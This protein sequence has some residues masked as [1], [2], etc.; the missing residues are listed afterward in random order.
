[1]DY[2]EVVFSLC[3]VLALVY[4][5]LL[6]PECSAS[7]ILEAILKFD[8]RIQQHVIETI[9][10]ELTAVAMPLFSSEIS[11]LTEFVSVGHTG[12]LR[13]FSL[14]KGDAGAFLADTKDDD[15]PL[16]IGV[17]ATNTD[18]GV[19]LIPTQSRTRPRLT[20]DSFSVA[21]ANADDPTDDAV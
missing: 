21:D 11:N 6:E 12:T 3:E 18:S 2:C 14:Y 16:P 10:S 17:S 8:A 5:K 1:L 15:E 19:H 13:K 20:P 7:N 4:N 9:V